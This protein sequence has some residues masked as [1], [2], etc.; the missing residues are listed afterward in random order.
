MQIEF[1]AS[2]RR[3]F[4]V[5]A[6]PASARR[7]LGVAVVLVAALL[8]STSAAF[9]RGQAKLATPDAST[10]LSATGDVLKDVS[11]IRRLDILQPVKSGVKS[12]DEIEQSVMSDLDESTTPEEFD[13]TSKTLIKLGMI[14]KGFHLREYVIKLLREQVAGYYEPKTKIFYLA[15]WL[16]ISEQKTVMAH[17]LTHALQDQH[18]NLRRF[19]KWPKG[20]SDAELAAHALME[21]E[22]TAVMLQYSAEKDGWNLDLAKVPSLTDRM[23]EQDSGDDTAKYPVLSGAPMVLKENLQ[24]PYVY[25]VGFVQGILKSRSWRQLD[26]C[27]VHLPA[28][29]K[30][31]MHPDRYL[32]HDDPV[33]IQIGDLSPA[34]G[35]GWKRADEDVNGEFGYMTLLTQFIN[36][37]SARVAAAGWSG[38]RYALYENPATGDSV[39]AQYTTWDTAKDARE[40]FDA[41]AERSEARY[42]ATRSAKSQPNDCVIETSEGLVYI[43]LRDKDVIVIE[44]AANQQQVAALSEVLWKSKKSLP[45]APSK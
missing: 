15:S 8:V 44:G 18:F 30:Q 36:K 5:F 27:Y 28:S 43:G 23:L 7:R 20:D 26:D 25:G 37:Q 4:G 31:I 21:G 32:A 34:L 11:R 24:F 41:Y 39:L 42:K 6:V 38:D 40:F 13:A 33:K 1:P 22:A 14:P 35:K 29:T 17:E 9:V 16:P 12:H 45:A 10:S 2:A 19:E 3:R